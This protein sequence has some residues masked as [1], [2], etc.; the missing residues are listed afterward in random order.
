MKRAALYSA[1]ILLLAACS[2]DTADERD[3]CSADTECQEAHVCVDGACEPIVCETS[4]D[5]P[6]AFFCVLSEDE[7]NYC[8][9]EGMPF[10]EPAPDVPTPQDDATH[11]E[12]VSPSEDDAEGPEEDATT[13]EVDATAPEEDATAPEEDA[14]APEEDVTTPEEDATTPEGDT[15]ETSD[16][17]GSTP[18]DCGA[19][20]QGLEPIDC[21]AYGD[22][23]A[24]CVFSNHCMCSEGFVC[25]ELYSPDMTVEECAA[26]SGCVVAPDM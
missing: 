22:V 5:C 3:T 19:P 15:E 7:A 25:E 11:Q 2:G 16:F 21:T 10:D 18:D 26:G 8:H 14:T 24:V 23:D 12:D 17:A 13:P 4:E 20:D 9:P 1:L 6:G